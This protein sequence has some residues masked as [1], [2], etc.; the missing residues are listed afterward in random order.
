MI[1]GDNP[2]YPVT[3]ARSKRFSII[4]GLQTCRQLIEAVGSLQEN[5]KEQK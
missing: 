5:E 3:L 4:E 1:F 2:G